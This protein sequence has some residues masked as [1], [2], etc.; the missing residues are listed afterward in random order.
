MNYICQF[1]KLTQTASK[2]RKKNWCNSSN[3]IYWIVTQRVLCLQKLIFV[4]FSN[5]VHKRYWLS[6]WHTLKVLKAIRKLS[7]LAFLLLLL[8]QT[9]K[10]SRGTYLVKKQN[11]SNLIEF[12]NQSNEIGLIHLYVQLS[13]FTKSNYYLLMF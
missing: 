6:S 7:F 10:F 12:C 8:K 13:F 11:H 2:S 5:I 3:D 4:C 9:H 1:D